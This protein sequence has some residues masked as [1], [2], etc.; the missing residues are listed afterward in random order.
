MAERLIVAPRTTAAGR[1]QVVE[2]SLVAA[3]SAILLGPAVIALET[4]GFRVRWVRWARQFATGVELTVERGVLPEVVAVGPLSTGRRALTPRVVCEVLVPG[5]LGSRSLGGVIS[6]TT[7]VALRAAREVMKRAPR[8]G[9]VARFERSLA[10]F[11]ISDYI[12][13]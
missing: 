4:I 3:R 9:P 10:H 7:A 5:A 13:M 1:R 8:A 11:L 12:I 2:R 6:R